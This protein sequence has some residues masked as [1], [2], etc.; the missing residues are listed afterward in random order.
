M[1]KMG[2]TKIVDNGAKDLKSVPAIQG[3]GEDLLD[4]FSQAVVGV[5]EKVANG[6]EH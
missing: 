2:E 1:T 5:A 3:R 6:C 4:A